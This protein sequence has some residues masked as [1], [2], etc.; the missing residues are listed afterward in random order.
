MPR[1]PAHDIAVW[2]G[3]NGHGT[4][5]GNSGWA[6]SV[7]TEPAKPESCIT[8]YDTGGGVDQPD[9]QFDDPTMQIRVRHKDYET[10]YEKIFSVTRALTLPTAL[11]TTD[12]HYSGFNV[13]TDIAMIG[14]DDNDRCIFTANLRLMRE[15][16]TP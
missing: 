7:G 16:L 1:S 14:K 15:P 11:E 6:I 8:L 5:A 13:F 3:D 2:L 4:F 9:A 10:G 12:Y